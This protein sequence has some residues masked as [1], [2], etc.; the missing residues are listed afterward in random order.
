MIDPAVVVVVMV[1]KEVPL[2]YIIAHV[3]YA[4]LRII[5]ELLYHYTSKS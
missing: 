3:M 5:F 2:V 1:E 4:L